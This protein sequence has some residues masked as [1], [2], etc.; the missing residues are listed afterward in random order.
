MIS[1]LVTYSQHSQT[2]PDMYE[3]PILLLLFTFDTPCADL[4]DLVA[5]LCA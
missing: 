1:C 2:Y 4:F 3:T 5:G